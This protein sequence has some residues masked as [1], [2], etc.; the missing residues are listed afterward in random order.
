MIVIFHHYL[1]LFIR[2]GLVTATTGL[3]V[4][5]AEDIPTFT[6]AVIDE[7][8]FAKI[9]SYIDHARSDPSC[10]I[11]IGGECDDSVGYYVQP[12]I[13]LTTDPQCRLLSEEIFGPVVTMFVYKDEEWAET[14]KLVDSTSPYALTGSIFCRDRPNTPSPRVGLSLKRPT[15]PSATLLETSISTT[16]ALV[17]WW[18]NNPSEVPELV[19]L[20]TRPSV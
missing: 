1:N 9:S 2:E 11:L 12:T 16:R 8:S 4:G 7:K 10:E 13:V 17:V 15:Q 6:S 5:S 14:V 20:M 19:A 18:D 3:K